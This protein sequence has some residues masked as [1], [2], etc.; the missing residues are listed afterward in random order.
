MDKRKV[1]L[2][3][4]V[5]LFSIIAISTA[6]ANTFVTVKIDNSKYSGNNQT[7][8]QG[9]AVTFTV[10]SNYTLPYTINVTVY[11]S[12]G[13][14]IWD[15]GVYKT[16]GTGYSG[17]WSFKATWGDNAKASDV[18]YEDTTNDT[19]LNVV[20]GQNY[21]VYYVLN[22]STPVFVAN[23]TF[24][25]M[26]KITSIKVDGVDIT[27]SKQKTIQAGSHTFWVNFTVYGSYKATTKI[28]NVKLNLT[29]FNAGTVDLSLASCNSTYGYYNFTGT[30]SLTKATYNS[31]WLL[32][33]RKIYITYDAVNNSTTNTIASY[34]NSTYKLNVTPANPYEWTFLDGFMSID[35]NDSIVG[36]NATVYIAVADMYGNVNTT[37]T[38]SYSGSILLDVLEG[39]VSASVKPDASP[40]VNATAGNWYVK[41]YV[42]VSGT[43]AKVKVRV[44]GGGLTTA[45][46]TI[47]YYPGVSYLQLTLN[48]T[49][50]YANN[51]DV[52]KLTVQMKDSDG[53]DV[54]VK[55][56]PITISEYTTLGLKFNG[57]TTLT[58]NTDDYGKVEV[59]V[60]AGTKAG[61]ANIYANIMT[62]TFAGTYGNTTLELKQAPNPAG[63][64]KS[65]LTS[66]VAGKAVEVW[67]KMVDYN[68]S[69]IAN[70]KDK[71]FEVEFNI[72]SG[73]AK[74]QENDAKVY[75]T[76]TNS[77]GY[78]VATVYTEN[79]TNNAVTIKVRWKNETGEWDPTVLPIAS[80]LAVTPNN[81]TDAKVYYSLDGVN[82]VEA[83]N[84]AVPN[85]KGTS[86][87]IRINLT[88]AYGNFNNTASGSMLVTTDNPSL[89]NMTNGSATVTNNLTVSITSGVGSFVYTINTTA[90]GTAHLTLNVTTFNFTKSF[91]VTTTGPKGVLIE[92]NNTA[93]VVGQPV[94]V[95]AWLTDA[96]GNKLAKSNVNLT[97]V[98]RKPDGNFLVITPDTSPTNASG[99]ATFTLTNATVKGSYK[100][101][102]SNA[103]YDISGTSTLW[104]Y[105]KAKSVEVEVN[106]TTVFVNDTVLITAY[107]KDE[108]GNVTKDL[109]GSSM[110]FYINDVLIDTKTVKNGEANTTYKFTSE[111]SYTITAMYNG[112]L[113]DE[114]SVTVSKPAAVIEYSDL[115]VTPTSGVVPLNVTISVKVTNT[116]TAAGEYNATLVIDGSIVDYKLGTLNASESTTVT[117]EHS[118]TEAGT[119][120]VTVD[121]L[122]PV[123]VTAL[124]PANVSV[125]SFTVEPTSGTAPLEVTINATVVNTGGVAGSITVYF[126]VNGSEIYNETIEVAAGATEYVTYAYTFK[127]AGTYNVTVDDL[128][129]V[130]VNVTSVCITG[131]VNGDGTVDVLD[132]TYL[133]N[134]IL[135]T[136]SATPCSDVNGD[137]SI[138]V[139]DLTYLVNLILGSTSALV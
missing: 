64:T 16:D 43:P 127:E 119:Y 85:V 30:A 21:S 20:P 58:V 111:G 84:V 15:A 27:S 45:E 79:A 59:L 106:K 40:S 95:T 136:A 125:T 128:P 124:S 93:P 139:L 91:T 135:G 29:K 26:P 36:S 9:E 8:L 31:S 104:F 22:A 33:F 23:I 18:D 71:G 60:K 34:T 133:V 5:L 53:N 92:F 138:D 3:V 6:A 65:S 73:D 88:D 11:N 47:E 121:D 70:S 78:A 52:A 134:V 102:I 90:E 28:S 49:S 117:F 57:S 62:G 67:L 1:S 131:D 48:K 113:W 115:N 112:T 99:A 100:V 101:T 69:V 50:L 54:K 24:D 86:I 97:I 74:W 80:S 89:G 120:N 108:D 109:D 10:T 25:S 37:F 39:G 110:K 82:Y 2:I 51:N 63:I 12:T 44:G 56:V 35:S 126:Y 32:E 107:V 130:E 129:P 77:T 81:V 19:T 87:T 41:R 42:T 76:G 72:T 68:N 17:S 14:K 55:G 122:T 103:T 75:V 61:T 66:I 38:G 13:V 4:A 96:S 7:F 118:F 132:L 94:K 123:T 46:K 105:G 137:G 98:V 114:T 83:N 116:G